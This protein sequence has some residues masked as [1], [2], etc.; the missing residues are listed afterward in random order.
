MRGGVTYNTP[1]LGTTTQAAILRTI[2]DNPDDDTPRLVLADWLDENGEAD[3]AEFIRVQIDLSRLA[4]SS[5]QASSLKSREQELLRA[6]EA[7]WRARL[8]ELHGVR[9]ESFDRGFVSAVRVDDPALFHA[10]ARAIFEAAPI[11]QLNLHRLF[12]TETAR[13]ART[14]QL[15]LSEHW[16]WK[17]AT[18]SAIRVWRTSPPRH[19]YVASEC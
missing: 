11:Q 5:P 2:L 3:R 6:H 4:V 19:I 10:H 1:M 14:E 17:M 8:P 9:W 16:I 7:E 15:P 12:P 13:F 18:A